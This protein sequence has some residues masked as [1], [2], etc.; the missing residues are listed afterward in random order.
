MDPKYSHE[1][2]SS[3]LFP[4]TDYDKYRE[5]GEREAL[6]PSAQQLEI[7]PNDKVSRRLKVP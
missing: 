7:F 2:I 4:P 1:G 6:H 3:T 5:P